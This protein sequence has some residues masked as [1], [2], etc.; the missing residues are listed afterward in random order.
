MK[1]LLVK[2]IQIKRKDFELNPLVSTWDLVQIFFFIVKRIFRGTWAG[3]FF[4]ENQGVTLIGKGARVRNKRF[5]TSKG[6]L[7]IE[8]NAEVQGISEDGLIFG[9]NVSIGQNALIRPSDYYGREIGKGLEIGD[10]SNIGPFNYVG[11]S[12]KITIGKNVMVGPR[13]SFYAENHVFESTDI[14]MKLQGIEKGEI[15]IGDDCWIASNSVIVSNVTIGEGSIVAS[16]SVV[17]KDVPPYSIV[18]GVPAK[19]IKSRKNV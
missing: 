10:N 4:K 15:I 13:V 9:A 19:V 7:I 11:C 17:T 18:A 2:I 8:E 3:L 6:N 5:I 16:G 14:P 12:G 1:S